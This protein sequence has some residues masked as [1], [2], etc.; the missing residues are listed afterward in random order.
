MKTYTTERGVTVSITPIPLLLDQI[1]NMHERPEVPTYAEKLAGGE[2][3]VEMTAKEMEA[4]KVHN[5]DWY[6]EHAE[7]WE[8]Y[9]EAWQ[10]SEA[11]LNQKLLDAIALKGVRFD[12]PDDDLWVEEQAF[13]GVTVPESGLA[14][15]VHYFKTEVLGGSKDIIKV[16]VMASGGEVDEEVLARAVDSFRGLLQ[17]AAVEGTINQVRAVD[18][19]PEATPDAGSGKVRADAVNLLGV[20]PS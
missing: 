12:L 16:M 3:Q 2:H 14:R 4:A 10:E 17:E 15:R 1:R 19:E 20:R 6:A 8:A 13:L 9:Q 11:A 18:H 7:V 5:P